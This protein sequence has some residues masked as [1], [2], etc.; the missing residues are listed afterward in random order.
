MDYLSNFSHAGTDWK[1]KFI[2]TQVVK[3]GVSCDIYNIS[4][5]ATKDLAI[6]RVKKGFSTPK[7]LIVKGSKTIE[8]YVSGKALLSVVT[9]NG[10]K[11]EYS[12]PSTK[13]SY[14]ELGIGATM[15]WRSTEDLTFYEICE[16]PYED[17]RFKDL[18]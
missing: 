11:I 15:Q 4:D 5:D 1:I 13:Q 18:D 17:G 16:P 6:V 3:T 10:E 12:F 2:E 7:Q 9:S 14:V 8:G